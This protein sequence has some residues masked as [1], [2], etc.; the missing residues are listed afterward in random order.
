[1]VVHHVKVDD[2][3]AGGHHR[4]NLFAQ[5]REVSGQNAGGNAKIFG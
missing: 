3:S 5:T 4:V 2:V 1:M